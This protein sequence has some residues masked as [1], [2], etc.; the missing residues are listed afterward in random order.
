MS[1]QVPVPIAAPATIG[2][3]GLGAMGLPMATRLLEAGYR[4][5]GF[6]VSGAMLSR[7]AAAG[8]TACKSPGATTNGATAVI[9][10]LPNSAIVQSVVLEDA[11]PLADS[12]ADAVLIDMSS[13]APTSTR[14]I[15]QRLAQRGLTMIDAPVSGGVQRATTGTLTIMAG[16]ETQHV[17]RVEPILATLGSVIFATGPLGSGHAMKALN[18]FMSAAGLTAACEA[19]RVGQQFGLDPGQMVDILNLSTGRNNSTENKIKPFVLS[20]S[21]AGGF[22]LALMAKDL[23]VAADLADAMGLASPLAHATAELWSQARDALPR[24]ADHTEID[25]FL[26]SLKR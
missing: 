21:Y 15:G 5:R 14:M 25:R 6:D 7:L 22:S 20:G 24:G 2:F 1:D 4:V 10:M 11:E 26:S 9:T 12:L 18:N 13:S 17:A 8:G 23:A 19:L 16:G 3:I